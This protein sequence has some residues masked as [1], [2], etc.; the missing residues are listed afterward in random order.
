[1]DQTLPH[2]LQEIKNWTVGRPRDEAMQ[3]ALGQ[4]YIL[5]IHYILRTVL[6]L[7]FDSHVLLTLY[8]VGL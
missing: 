7:D 3:A 4:D 1:M 2:V 6:I 5:Y 8:I